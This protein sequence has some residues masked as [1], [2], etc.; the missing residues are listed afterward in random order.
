MIYGSQFR[1]L[2]SVTAFIENTST[3]DLVTIVGIAWSGV[4]IDWDDGYSTLIQRTIWCGW[5]KLVNSRR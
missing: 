1:T 2:K 4:S 3:S 5:R